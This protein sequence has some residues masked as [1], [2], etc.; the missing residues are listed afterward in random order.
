MQYIICKQ[1]K[2]LECFLKKQGWVTNRVKW[3]AGLGTQT[4]RGPKSPRLTVCWLVG[5]GLIAN[6]FGNTV[7]TGCLWLNKSVHN[8]TVIHKQ[9]FSKGL[10]V[11]FWAYVQNIIKLPFI[12]CRVLDW[13]FQATGPS[14]TQ[15][16]QPCK[17]GFDCLPE[18]LFLWYD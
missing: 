14:S 1:T 6:F 5:F 11:G 9:F 15:V 2:A 7:L 4:S 18:K 3:A 17:K 10:L 13:N 16:N 8:Q 12:V